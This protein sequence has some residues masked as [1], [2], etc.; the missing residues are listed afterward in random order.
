MKKMARWGAS[1]L[2]RGGCLC[3]LLAS[4]GLGWGREVAP[5]TRAAVTPPRDPFAAFDDEFALDPVAD[6]DVRT[7]DPLRVYNRAMFHVNDKIYFWVLKPV[8]RTYGKVTPEGA[9]RCVSRFGR[10][11]G[12][13]VRFVNHCLQ[14][15][16]RN[17]VTE[18]SRFSINSTVGILGVLDVAESAFD[19][20]A[21][22]EDFGQTLGR[23]GVG[24]GWP[25]VLPV[26][27]QSTVRDAV[28]TFADG[29]LSPL[30]YVEPTEAVI[31][32]RVYEAV[33]YVSLHIG[34]YEAIKEEGLDPYTFMRDAYLQ[35]RT[36]L[37]RE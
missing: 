19:L 36:A 31:G 27:G 29:W 16:F 11:L 7:S 9:R 17:A 33:N 21:E 13:P 32:V 4:A 34:Q 8:A 37:I 3:L 26:L 15:K 18:F 10:N 23:Y 14:G 12:F 2:A 6:T 28:G 25:I 24:A 20:R 22:R 1:G 35:R 5:A 30:R